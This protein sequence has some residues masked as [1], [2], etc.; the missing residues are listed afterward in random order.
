[1]R[2]RLKTMALGLLTA[3]L[4][5]V[6]VAGEAD[7]LS[8]RFWVRLSG[9][10]AAVQPSPRYKVAVDADGRLELTVFAAETEPLGDFRVTSRDTVAAGAWHHVAFSYSLQQRRV[11]L[12][13]DGRLQWENDNIA[14]PRLDAVGRFFAERNAGEV[15]EFTLF[16]F[17]AERDELT[18]ASAEEIATWGAKARTLAD[19]LAKTAA[20]ERLRK[21]GAELAGYYAYFAK[22]TAKA[23]YGTFTLKRVKE[24]C[25][26]VGKLLRVAKGAPS[27]AVGDG[28]ALAG[29]DAMTQ[30]QTLPRDIPSDAD[31]S[32][33]LQVFACPGEYEPAGLLVYAWEPLAGA[34][35]VVSDL[36]CGDA[37]IKASEVD[38]KIVKR[39]YRTGGAWLHYFKDNR[40][41]YLVPDLLINDDSLVKVDEDR[42]RNYLRLD[43]PEGARY[44]D[45]GDPAKCHVSWRGWQKENAPIP[46]EDAKELQPF[47]IGAAGRNQFL[48]LTFHVPEGQKPGLYTGEVTVSAGG[49]SVKKRIELKVLPIALPREGSPYAN[50]DDV[51]ISHMNSFFDG[52]IRGVTTAER[53]EYALDQMRNIRAHNLFHTTG[54]WSKPEYVQLAREAGFVPDKVFG[55]PRGVADQLAGCWYKICWDTFF[56]GEPFGNLTAADREMGKRAVRRA[57]QPWMDYRRANGLDKSDEYVIFWSESAHYERIGRDQAELGEVPRELGFKIFAHGFS[58]NRWWSSDVQDMHSSIS[59]LEDEARHWH[60]ANAELINYCDPFPSS[61]CPAFMRR[62]PGFWMYKKGLD[63]QMMHG[64]LADR[65]P[66]IEWADDWGGDGSYRNFC[67]G[68]PTRNGDIY[69]LAWEGLREAYDDVRYATR[70]RQLGAANADAKDVFLRREA[71]RA[72]NWL[73]RQDARLTDINMVRAGIAERIVILQEAIAKHGGTLPDPNANAMKYAEGGAK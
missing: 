3:A 30:E 29:F 55:G 47:D 36:V 20:P 60:A 68:Y 2:Q 27:V 38:R 56:N 7:E 69:K 11:C 62:K 40:G 48:L 46:F 25:D 44:V 10:P 73:E 5:G 19:E 8:S 61:E 50:P 4:A 28:F 57:F 66:W 23:G 65:C 9:L 64:F 17:A 52:G 21:L 59:I 34:K 35:A 24:T 39:W 14:V 43:C 41:R 18:M 42:M 33:R 71:R 12:Y 15:R 63:G 13:L 45:V 32:D 31:F 1:M 26:F 70:L 16:P 54:L 58:A 49:K 67:M 72:L 6:S 37:A 51:Y 22:Q 53:R